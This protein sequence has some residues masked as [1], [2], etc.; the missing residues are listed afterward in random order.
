MNLT[1]TYN[2]PPPTTEP[3][4]SYSIKNTDTVNNT[5]IRPS[6]GSGLEV[7]PEPTIS[8]IPLII[9]QGEG[10]FSKDMNGSIT[11]DLGYNFKRDYNKTLNPRYIEFHD[12][13]ITHVINSN[14]PTNIYADFTDDHKIFGN[15][16]LDNNVTFVYGRAK[17][18][19]YFYDD[20][21][22]DNINTPNSIVV[23]CDQDP[24]TCSAVYN[25]ETVLS[26]TEEFDW[27]LSRGHVTTDGDGDITLVASTGGD[28]TNDNPVAINNSGGIN[29]P[30]VNVSATVA[31]RPLDV[32]INFGSDTNRWL[33]YNQ[34]LDAIPSPYYRV[35]FIGQS[36]WAGAGDT[37]HTVDGETSIQKNRRL[38]W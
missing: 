5:V 24:I 10:N 7:P 18:S 13:N 28:V 35:R 14:T 30:N 17:P 11:M 19:Q 12:F 15:K 20:V 3:Y 9:T 31:N 22:E 8:S 21:V 32:F 6:A 2:S 38:G 1:F 25:I 29:N 33:I 16:D 36:D 23:Y 27:Y 34:Y 4:L 37:G 26:K